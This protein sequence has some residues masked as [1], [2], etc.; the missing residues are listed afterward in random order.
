MVISYADIVR[1]AIYPLENNS[2]LVIDP[3]AV[4]SA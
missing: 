4:K 3:D 2:E 1:L